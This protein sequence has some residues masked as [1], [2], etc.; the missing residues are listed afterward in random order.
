[1]CVAESL[2]MPAL[3]D[4]D[5]PS[6]KCLVQIPRLQGL[7]PDK[8]FTAIRLQII[9]NTHY[10]LHMTLNSEILGLMLLCKHGLVHK[11]TAQ[12]S[13]CSSPMCKSCYSVWSGSAMGT[14]S[15]V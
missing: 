15:F 6:Q 12:S 14:S 3:D 10:N 11:P 9:Y 7:L 1:M 2:I 8:D 13:V 5:K 4:G